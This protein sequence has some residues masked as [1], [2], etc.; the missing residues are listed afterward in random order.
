MSI[1]N[2]S[3]TSPTKAVENT[4]VW[5]NVETIFSYKNNLFM[6]T[7]TGLVIYSVEDPLNPT[8]CSSIQHVYGGD[9]VVVED[10]LAYVTIH[11][12][13][14]CGQ[15]NNELLIM[16]VSDVYQPRQIASFAMKNPKGL[17][18]DNGNLFLCDDGLKVFKV[19][20][21]S[22]PLSLN[23]LAHYTGMDGYD[24]IPFDHTLMMIADNGL[25]QYDYSDM[26]TIKKLSVL[27]VKNKK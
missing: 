6:G 10:D 2:L 1:F 22:D 13:N 27:P 3:G 25:Y 24:V 11:S 16:N 21:E 9:P 19:N 14:F 18:I 12:G 8:Y 23:T 5:W 7:P 20:S 15:D 26:N 4:N 17:G